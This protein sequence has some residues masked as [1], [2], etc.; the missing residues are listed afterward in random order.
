M[1]QNYSEYLVAN[2]DVFIPT[3]WQSYQLI[4]YY[5]VSMFSKAFSLFKK[6][7]EEEEKI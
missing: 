6:K 3:Q 7:E 2:N 1:K 4:Q 5:S